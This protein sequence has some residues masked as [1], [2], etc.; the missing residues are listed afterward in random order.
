MEK[1]NFDDLS[2]ELKMGREIE[3][4]Y[5]NDQYSI[6]NSVDGYWYLYRDSTKTELLKIC[7][8]NDTQK[9]MNTVAQYQINGTS[10]KDIFDG[11]KYDAESLII[12]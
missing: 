10:I 3:F 8:F 9:L 12:L 5:N 11:Y 4:E 7:E 2:K 1:Y 6:T